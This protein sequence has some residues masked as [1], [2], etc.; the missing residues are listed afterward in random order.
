[1]FFFFFF[2][3]LS[4]RIQLTHPQKLKKEDIKAPE[5]PQR[6][7]SWEEVLKEPVYDTTYPLVSDVATTACGVRR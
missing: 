6:K 4:L 3:T 7:K 5:K 2:L 1:M